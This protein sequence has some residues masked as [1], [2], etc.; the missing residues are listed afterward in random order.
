MTPSEASVL[1]SIAWLPVAGQKKLEFQQDL[2]FA[3]LTA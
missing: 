2:S 3:A 1:A